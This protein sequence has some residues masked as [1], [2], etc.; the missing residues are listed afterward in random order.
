MSQI[1]DQ[2]KEG[3]DIVELVREYVPSLKKMGLNWKAPCP[4]HQEK[5]PSF[6]VSPEK[7]IWHCFG[8]GK[9]GDVFGFVR[10]SEG[11]E[12]GDALRLLAKRAGI[13]LEKQDPKAESERTRLLDMLKLSASWYHQSLLKAKSGD[14]AREY[15]ASRKVKADTQANWQL[16]FGPDAWEGLS[17]Y[18]RSRG[19]QDQEIIKA[20]LASQNDRGGV[21]DRFRNR[22]MFPINDVHG[23]VVGFTARKLNEEDVGGKYINTPETIIYHKSQ[24]LYGLSKAKQEI[25]AKDLVVVVEGNM[26]CLSSHEAGISNVVASSGT[27]L[28]GDQVRLLKRFTKNIALAF[29]PDTAGQEALLRGLEI[30]WR[31]DMHISVI[32]L[33]DSKDPDDLI[34]EDVLKWE[35]AI[36]GRVDFMD[37]LFN[38]IQ[39]KYDVK[40]AQGKKQM[41]G[42]LLAW[43]SR[44]PDPIEQTHYIQKLSNTISV[45]ESVLR[46]VVA[47][48]TRLPSGQG[49][50]ASTGPQAKTENTVPK[51]QDILHKVGIRLFALLL[52]SKAR[53]EI[54]AEWLQRED[55]LLLYKNK[56]ELYD[57]RIDNLPEMVQPLARE[58]TII[59]DQ[60]KDDMAEEDRAEEINQLIRRLEESY[61]RTLLSKIRQEIKSAEDSGD[62]EQMQNHLQKWQDL[63]KKIQS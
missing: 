34:K 15:L 58:I 30:A 44:I 19:C 53:P 38:S 21:Y 24:V 7:Q 51:Q 47:K 10:E 59:S 8:C 12:F 16:G 36:E 35:S 41:A 62:V 9:G 48:K 18:L 26:D 11:V 1:T 63:H 42:Q 4:F 54:S 45:E 37:Y 61:T 52:I 55:M 6:V 43:I 32:V 3:V 46:S 13:K 31:E 14:K 5:T 22:L 60:L 57:W 28:T 29:D 40:T 49:P 20:G 25:R 17:T 33:P 27:A 50:Q 56:E 2:I 39:K 23:S